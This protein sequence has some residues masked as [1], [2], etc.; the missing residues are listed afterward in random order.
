MSRRVRHYPV[1][2]G[3]SYLPDHDLVVTAR[4]LLAI[5]ASTDPKWEPPKEEP[6][7]KPM[8]GMPAIV[9]HG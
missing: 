7:V 3:Y 1:E 9:H 4:E 2:G 6:A 5:Q 8:P